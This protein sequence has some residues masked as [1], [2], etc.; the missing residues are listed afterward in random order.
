MKFSEL[1]SKYLN[2]CR[3]WHLFRKTIEA[4]KEVTITNKIM[5]ETL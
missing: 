4:V 2:H 5:T 1:L 3:K